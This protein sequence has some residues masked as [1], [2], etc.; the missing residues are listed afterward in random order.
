MLKNFVLSMNE[1]MKN[2]NNNILENNYII[3]NLEKDKVEGIIQVLFYLLYFDYIK[4]I[5]MD[6]TFQ[7]FNKIITNS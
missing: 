7:I 2:L 6:E 4:S 3:T 1:E 5:K